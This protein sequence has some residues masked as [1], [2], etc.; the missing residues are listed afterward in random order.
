MSRSLIPGE[1]SRVSDHVHRVVAPNPGPMTGPGTNSYI[2]GKQQAGKKQ[3]GKQ[4]LAI[5]DPGPAE[6]S[7]IEALLAACAQLGE[8][9]WIIATHTHHDHSPAAALLA[10]RSGAEVLGPAPLGDDFQDVSFQPGK[11]FQHNEVFTA[12]GVHIRALH[13]PGHVGNHY[14]Y[15]VEED[16][17]LM[18][19]DH[20]MHG[21]TV[22]IIP[23]SGDMKDYLASLELLKAYAIKHLAPGHGDIMDNPYEVIQ[24]I[25]DHRLQR[26]AKVIAGMQRLRQASL[27]ELTPVVYDDVDAS[28]HPIAQLSLLAH[29]IKL[30]K[31]HQVSQENNTWRARF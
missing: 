12:A 5:I 6:P 25:I 23:P 2:V 18:T 24:G 15:I 29:L 31:E 19:G 9:R 10:E 16:Q 28:L 22:V 3:A 1:L 17:L 14:C 11:Q 20:I 30:E 27:D 7:H 21:S 8:L 4:Q 13:T 26:E